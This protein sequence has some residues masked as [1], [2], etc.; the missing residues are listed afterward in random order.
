MARGRGF[1]GRIADAAGRVA[2][3]ITRPIERLFEGTREPRPQP[4]PPTPTGPPRER[5]EPSRRERERRLADPWRT[6]W[7]EQLGRRG[8]LPSGRRPSYLDNKDFVQDMASDLDLDADETMDFWQ[9]YIKYM[10]RGKSRY[11][12]RDIRNPF[13][14]RWNIHPD[15]FDWWEWR[16]A[17]GYRQPGQSAA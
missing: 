12:R 13:W 14:Q 3:A 1:F 17:M 11:L 5:E 6:E 15:T 10:V 16:E 7:R 4:S 9:D 8:R 2:D